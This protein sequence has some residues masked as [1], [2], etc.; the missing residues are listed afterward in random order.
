M[1][2]ITS[3]EGIM[4][5][6]FDWYALSLSNVILNYRTGGKLLSTFVHSAS[7]TSGNMEITNKSAP[8]G[9]G[10]GCKAFTYD[11]KANKWDMFW[12]Y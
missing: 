10:I 12:F 7:W 2:T 11:N 6:A 8:I 3:G 9:H 5:L 1:K 4:D